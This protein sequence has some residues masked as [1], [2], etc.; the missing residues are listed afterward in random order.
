MRFLISFLGFSFT[1]ITHAGICS[2]CVIPFFAFLFLGMGYDQL[3]MNPRFIP[4]IRSMTRRV[5]VKAARKLVDKAL[6]LDTA[7]EIAEF[8]IAEVSH[9]VA[10]DLA[11]FI[12]EIRGSRLHGAEASG[13]R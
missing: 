2:L 12:K 8:L 6:T 11:P 7:R 3:S 9:H 10:G 13:E 4:E 1:T 5:T